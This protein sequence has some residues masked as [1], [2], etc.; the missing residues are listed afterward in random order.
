LS[1]VAWSLGGDE[2]WSSERDGISATSLTGKT[3]MVWNVPGGFLQDIARDGRVLCGLNSSRR[4]IVGFSSADN[5]ERNLT[6]LNW[7]FPKGISADGRTVLF[8]EQNLQPQAVYLRK[9]DGSAAA[10]V[11]DGGAWGFSPDGQWIL[12][13][14]RDTP[15]SSRIVLMPTGA[16]EPKPLPKTDILV[17]A[18]TWFPDGR[19][20][21][22]A[23]NEPAHG[24]RLF[25]QD[26]PDGK[27]R[28]ITPEGV[29]I[30]FD[31]I[32]P[33]GKS[34]V[35]TGTDQK[36]D[37]YPVEPGEPRAVP[38]MD[39][40][41]VTLRWTHDGN[42]IFVYR[43]SAPPLRVERVDVRTGQR[44]L[45]KEIRP[46]DPSGVE[47]VGPIMIAPDEKSYV[48]SYRRSLDEL[49]LAT[50]LH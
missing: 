37:L 14:R 29:N 13:I 19:R 24:S 22:F 6:W 18:A 42:S 15:T 25:I 48:Y 44:T 47:Q 40:L 12:T 31:V 39:P 1:G 20:I 34:I 3:R 38:G 2:V 49:Y 17:G 45:W 41:D 43:P 23:G 9:L 27:P 21:L 10:R 4:E 35:A 5:S 16:G 8:E 50:G 30:R 32:S 11:S 28:P 26:I 33:D 36:I 7:S 46:P